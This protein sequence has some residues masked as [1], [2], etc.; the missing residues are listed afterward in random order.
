MHRVCAINHFTISTNRNAKPVVNQ[1]PL[2]LRNA[3]LD[4]HVADRR[5]RQPV[6]RNNDAPRR[7]RSPQRPCETA[8]S[9]ADNVVQCAGSRII[10]AGLSPVELAQSAAHPHSH[11]SPVSI[12]ADVL[13]RTTGGAHPD[14]SLIE[15][16][17]LPRIR[18]RLSF[19]S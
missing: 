3:V 2:E 15:D 11:L 12:E 13:I 1:D 16:L 8:R 9:C 7:E 6:R 19:N 5:R 17:M 10:G 14:P 4:D 18:F